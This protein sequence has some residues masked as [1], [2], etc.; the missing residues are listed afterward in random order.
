E[1]IKTREDNEHKITKLMVT[2]SLDQLF[3]T[4]S[5]RELLRLQTKNKSLDEEK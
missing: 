1:L 5:P 3:S 2:G 4:L